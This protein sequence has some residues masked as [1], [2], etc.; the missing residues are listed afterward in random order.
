MQ[1][2]PNPQGISVPTEA[3][4][5]CLDPPAAPAAQQMALVLSLCPE[6]HPEQPF[7]PLT[8]TL[9]EPRAPVACRMC[10]GWSHVC[11][12][13]VPCVSHVCAMRVPYVSH[14]CGICV[15]Y[16]SHVC[17]MCVQACKTAGLAALGCR[18]ARAR[19]L[20]H[21]YTRTHPPLPPPHTHACACTCRHACPAHL[22]ECGRQLGHTRV[23]VQG[24]QRLRPRHGRAHAA[25][26]QDACQGAGD[27]AVLQ[28]GKHGRPRMRAFVVLQWWARVCLGVLTCLCLCAC[29]SLTVHTRMQQ[30]LT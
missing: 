26:Q 9:H 10:A 2:P 8:H 25:L 7:S 18:A 27:A 16:V 12:M 24:V 15:P 17:A 29:V 28:G 11:A 1:V 3:S 21:S 13:C 23:G 4:A 30:H 5:Q 19:Q 20:A 22:T 6:Q 14:V